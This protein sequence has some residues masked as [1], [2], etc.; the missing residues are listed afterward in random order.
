MINASALLLTF[1]VLWLLVHIFLQAL[2]ATRELGIDWNIGARDGNDQIKTIAAQRA[3]RAS[4]NY[5]ETLPAFIALIVASFVYPVDQGYCLL[6][7]SIWAVA[8]ILYLPLYLYGV[9]FWRTM[10]WGISI[11]GLLIMVLAMWC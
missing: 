6:G 1:S 11:I 3:S 7:G 8:R 5:Q 2:L 10:I 4:R 9:K